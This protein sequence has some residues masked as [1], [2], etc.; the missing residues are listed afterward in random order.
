MVWTCSFHVDS[1]TSENKGQA[2]EIKSSAHRSHNMSAFAP[3][4]IIH[5]G[6]TEDWGRY[7]V[8]EEA[9]PLNG[10]LIVPVQ[11]PHTHLILDI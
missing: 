4:L 7:T 8:C 9:N 5:Q 1:L 11:T 2:N 6:C 10:S 3:E